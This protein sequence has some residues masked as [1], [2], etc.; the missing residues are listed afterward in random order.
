MPAKLKETPLRREVKVLGVMT[1]VVI[2]MTDMGLSMKV[3][4]AHKELFAT[5]TQIAEKLPTIG[6]IKP[7]YLANDPI[8]F[9]QHQALKKGKTAS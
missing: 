3:K 1:P 6:D 7:A 2:G 5:W 4:G 8:K 9:L